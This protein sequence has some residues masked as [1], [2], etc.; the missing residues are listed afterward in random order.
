[1]TSL[2]MH[3]GSLAVGLLKI[4]ISGLSSFASWNLATPNR[5]ICILAIKNSAATQFVSICFPC[6][7]AYGSHNEQADIHAVCV[8]TY[9]RLS[10]L[11]FR[12][13]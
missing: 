1:M 11:G 10:L 13:R 8:V 9:L 5:Y 4:G 3:G 2:S 12:R 6:L 7:L